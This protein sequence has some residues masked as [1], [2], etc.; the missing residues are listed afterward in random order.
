M[1]LETDGTLEGETVS[2]GSPDS[3]YVVDSRPFA[4]WG[5]GFDLFGQA[6]NTVVGLGGTQSKY[7][8]AIQ[9]P[10]GTV[11]YAPNGSK[12]SI[13]ITADIRTAMEFFKSRGWTP[14]QA[15]GIVALLVA[16]RGLITNGQMGEASNLA[17]LPKDQ[18]KKLSDAYAKDSNGQKTDQTPLLKGLELVQY[19]LTHGNGAAIGDQLK[20][21]ATAA[22]AGTVIAKYYGITNTANLV[23]SS[24]FSPIKAAIASHNIVTG[25][26]GQCLQHVADALQAGGLDIRPLLRPRI[27]QTGEGTHWAKDTG[28]ALVKAGW[29]VV[30]RGY[31]A[32][33]DKNANYHPELGDVAVWLGGPFGHVELY[34]VNRQDPRNG[35]WQFGAQS[36]KS[37]WTGLSDPDARGEV[38]ILRHPQN[39]VAA[40][41]AQATNLS[42]QYSQATAT[43][44]VP[45]AQGQDVHTLPN[46]GSIVY[47]SYGTKGAGHSGKLY[48]P[49]G[50]MVASSGRI[51]NV[52]GH[53]VNGIDNPAAANI[54]DVGAMP[55]GMYEVVLEKGT[56]HGSH[57]VRYVPL[58][59][60]DVHDRTGLLGHS[61]LMRK[62]RLADGEVVSQSHGCLVTDQNEAYIATIREMAQKGPVYLMVGTEE[63]I[64]AAMHKQTPPEET[65]DKKTPEQ[66]DGMKQRK[67]PPSTLRVSDAKATPDHRAAAKTEADSGSTAGPIIADAGKHYAPGASM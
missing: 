11:S 45:T 42:K 37:N 66:T 44:P 7:G 28:E 58:E 5:G 29:S 31:G 38:V 27:S 34:G 16:K 22:D 50:E 46:G 10:D 1:A 33:L 55:P 53:V 14:E 65:A 49:N 63:Q 15:S 23:D 21:A 40:L 57:F 8:R 25:A 60:T 24:G 4:V 32:D 3:E 17:D 48:T 54:K 18:F 35:A 26:D 20:Q 67:E 62:V 56:F 52:N 64:Q 43:A 19:D 12:L 9:N 41:A 47:F 59:G 51:A 61:P 30:A 36:S 13:N 2:G 39:P 6:Y